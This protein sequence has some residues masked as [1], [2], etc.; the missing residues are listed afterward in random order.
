[1]R[2]DGGRACQRRIM[3]RRPRSLSRATAA[4]RALRVGLLFKRLLQDLEDREIARSSCSS[5]AADDVHKRRDEDGHAIDLNSG[6]P[7]SESRKRSNTVDRAHEVHLQAIIVA[8]N[9]VEIGSRVVGPQDRCPQVFRQ[10]FELDQVSR[11]LPKQEIEVNRRHRGSLKRRRGVADED[12]FEV[13]LMQVAPDL[14]EQELRV[15]AASIAASSPARL[16]MSL[17]S[18]RF[19]VLR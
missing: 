12:R 11:R 14:D 5:L 9:P 16:P 2:F 19:R 1:M 15:H 8:D 6:G 7:I 13:E 17:L 10:R 3:S 18:L 4:S